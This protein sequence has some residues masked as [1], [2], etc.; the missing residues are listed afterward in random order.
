MASETHDD[1]WARALVEELTAVRHR[2]A[3]LAGGEPLGLRA[4]EP[5]PGRRWYLCAFEGPAF[6]CLDI[7]LAPE[8]RGEAVREVAS[9]SMLVEGAEALIDSAEL[10][11]LAGAAARL[12][13]TTSEPPEVAAA[14]ES[15]AQ[16]ALEL[17]GWR[18]SPRREIASVPALDTAV[19][20]HGAFARAYGRFVD[21]SE[22]LV[23]RQDELEPETVSALRVF[24]EAA[25]RAGVGEPLAAR[26]GALVE[27]SD[28][29]AGQ[30]LEAYLRPLD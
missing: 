30:V 12:L 3:S 10:G 22:P 21:A 16:G 5:A 14:V 15:V 23:S 1:D 4:V 17:A 25:G 11:Y 29:A 6:L 24:E 9:G 27:D 26:L 18:D 28:E 7:E 19:A 8:L 2:A 13:T 20:L